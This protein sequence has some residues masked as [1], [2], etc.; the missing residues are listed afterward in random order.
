MRA[1]I[2][3]YSYL[4]SQGTWHVIN[5]QE[6][7]EELAKIRNLDNYVGE[8]RGKTCC[9]SYKNV[10]YISSYDYWSLAPLSIQK[11]E[12]GLISDWT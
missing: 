1:E 9:V 8:E 6:R 3:L 5:A 2:R 12:I 10:C 4:Y 7:L 11:G